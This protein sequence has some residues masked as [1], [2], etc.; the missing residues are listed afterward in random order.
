MQDL[1]VEYAGLLFTA[2]QHCHTTRGTV[3]AQTLVGPKA[4]LT[5]ILTLTLRRT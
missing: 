4:Q 5:L 3:T 2:S 1:R